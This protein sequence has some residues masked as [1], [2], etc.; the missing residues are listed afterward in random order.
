M[1]PKAP[2]TNTLKKTRITITLHYKPRFLA[3]KL[4]DR[5]ATNNTVFDLAGISI[6]ASKCEISD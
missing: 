2:A 1:P 4:V 3:I 6:A 5:T